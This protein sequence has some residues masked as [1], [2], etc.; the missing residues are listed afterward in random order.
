[1]LD[2]FSRVLLAN[3]SKCIYMQSDDNRTF[4]L[5]YGRTDFTRHKAR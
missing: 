2:A 5:I 4:G 3:A 1:M